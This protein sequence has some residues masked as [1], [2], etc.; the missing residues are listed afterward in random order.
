VF[1]V[2][3]ISVQDHLSRKCKNN[4]NVKQSAASP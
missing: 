3:I 1:W 4:G 2:L